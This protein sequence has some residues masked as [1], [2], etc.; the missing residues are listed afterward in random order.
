MVLGAIFRVRHKTWGQQPISC[1]VRA[2]QSATLLPISC[3][4]VLPVPARVEE[5]ISPSKAIFKRWCYEQS[6]LS[7]DALSQHGNVGCQYWHSDASAYFAAG[8]EHDRREPI[9]FTCAI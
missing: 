4:A 8:G 3:K 5:P 2:W 6:T 1:Q 7:Q 9:T